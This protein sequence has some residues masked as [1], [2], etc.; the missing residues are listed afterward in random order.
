MVLFIPVN[1]I[2][3]F[4]DC[5]FEMVN[6]CF[7]SWEGAGNVLLLEEEMKFYENLKEYSNYAN[8]LK[9]LIR[10][11]ELQQVKI[12]ALQSKYFVLTNPQ[13]I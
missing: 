5:N 12:E 11:Y 2:Y 7:I 9:D 6:L 13:R 4:Y 8:S 3:R 1:N 10:K